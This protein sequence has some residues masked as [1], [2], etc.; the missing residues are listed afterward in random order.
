MNQRF[1]DDAIKDWTNVIVLHWIAL[2][3]HFTLTWYFNRC[4]R[5]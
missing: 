5:M 1:Q 2:H 3:L 4:H